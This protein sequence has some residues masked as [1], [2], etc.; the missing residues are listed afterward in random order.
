[1]NLSNLIGLT[2]D[3]C[4]FSKSGYSFEFSDNVDGIFRHFKLNTSF[5]VSFSKEN[6]IDAEDSFSV[7]VW[8]LLENQVLDIQVDEA[9]SSIFISF[10]EQQVIVI[11]PGG[12]PVIDNLAILEDLT[13][14]EWSPIL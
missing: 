2:L 12:L 5:C 4:Q 7:G 8:G 14:S 3:R 1:M 10:G 13:S 11:W 9:N 6:L